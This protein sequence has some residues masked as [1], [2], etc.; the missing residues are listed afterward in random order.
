[1]VIKSEVVVNLLLTLLVFI[2]SATIALCQVAEEEPYENDVYS[3][4]NT[5]SEYDNVSA[6]RGF[7]LDNDW[8]N[9]DVSID[10]LD[11]ILVLTGQLSNEFFPS[12]PRSLVLSMISVES[13]FR[14]DLVGFND[15]SGLMQIIPKYHRNRIEKYIYEERVDVFDARVNIM[16]GMDYLKELLDWSMGDLELAVMSYNMGPTRA[17][18]YASH[19]YTSSYC[20]EVLERMFAIQSFLEG[21]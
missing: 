18:H 2:P 1:M 16:V 3:L 6:L 13:G 4:W 14:K 5:M 7:L 21:R 17:T 11:Y 10:D 20:I 12:I 19:G 15:D 9:D 8:I